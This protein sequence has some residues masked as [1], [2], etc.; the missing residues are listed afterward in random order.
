ML[1][2]DNAHYRKVVATDLDSTYYCAKYA[3]QHWRRQKKEGTTVDGR[4]LE[5]FTYGKF[6][7]T[8]SMSGHVVNIPQLQAAYNAAKAGIIHLGKPAFL[9]VD[10]DRPFID[11]VRL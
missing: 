1:D 8:A 4:P 10:L 3:G 11:L 9:H 6:I 2:G 5:G 7:A